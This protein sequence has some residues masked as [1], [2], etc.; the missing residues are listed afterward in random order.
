MAFRVICDQCGAEATVAPFRGSVMPP[1]NW[2]VV[3]SGPNTWVFE[4]YVCLE[5]FLHQREIRLRGGLTVLTDKE[6]M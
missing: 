6:E 4:K 2:Y 3:S 5:I 1:A